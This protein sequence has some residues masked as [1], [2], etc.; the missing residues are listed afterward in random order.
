LQ[1][2]VADYQSSIDEELPPVHFHSGDCNTILVDKVFP[3][4]DYRQ[5]RRALCFLDPYGLDVRWGVLEAAGQQ[6]TIDLLLNF[7]IMNLNRNALPASRNALTDVHRERMEL[8]WGAGWEEELY[9]PTPEPDLFEEQYE[10]IEQE[11]IVTAY[12]NRLVHL[13]GFKFCSEPILFVNSKNAPLY[14]LLF[15]SPNQK[16]AKNISSYLVKKYR[17]YVVT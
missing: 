16:A 15:A 7:S 17:N 10:K 1:N 14:Y 4:I 12:G 9:A 2:A 13:A 11:R 3:L 8:A 6:G 5:Y